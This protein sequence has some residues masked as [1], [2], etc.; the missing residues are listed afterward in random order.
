L[1]G[2]RKSKNEKKNTKRQ[3]LVPYNWW[4]EKNS[5]EIECDSIAVAG[6]ILGGAIS[7]KFIL[8]RGML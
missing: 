6:A 5:C 3:Y 2:A 1:E 7:I 4:T 8:V